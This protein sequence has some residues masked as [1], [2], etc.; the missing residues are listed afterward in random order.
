MQLR[1]VR[2][3]NL[4][5]HG[6]AEAPQA[7]VIKNAHVRTYV[8]RLSILH[9]VLHP[10]AQRPP[11][12]AP[13]PPAAAHRAP[14]ATCP[15]TAQ[16]AAS[17]SGTGCRTHPPAA[18][19]YSSTYVTPRLTHQGRFIP[20]CAPCMFPK[21]GTACQRPSAAASP[22]M[23]RMVG[24]AACQHACQPNSLIQ[25]KGVKLLPKGLR[26]TAQGKQHAHIPHAHST[27]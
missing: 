17:H 1:S 15:G 6:I 9:H 26:N 7:Q 25:V 24:K 23:L 20:P 3:V 21:A 5:V 4:C 16:C 19:Q 27:A 11:A 8:C 2:K 12:S 10:C 13:Y 14:Q 18:Q 22:M